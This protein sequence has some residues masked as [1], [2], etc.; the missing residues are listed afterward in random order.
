[1]FVGKLYIGS[2]TKVGGSSMKSNTFFRGT[3]PTLEISMGRGIKVENIDSLIVYFSQGI[4]V[5]KKK[6]EDVKINKTTNLVYVPLSELETYM[7]S[8]SVVNVQLRYKLLN[9]T[10]IYSTHI[11]PFRVLKQVCDGVF[12]E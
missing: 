1:M 4:T 11:Y 12:I 2:V 10:N 6:L 8:P 9:D 7:F 3:T 5:L